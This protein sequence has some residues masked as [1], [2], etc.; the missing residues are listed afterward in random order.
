MPSS[1]RQM[2]GYVSC[3]CAGQGHRWGGRGGRVLLWS[4]FLTSA[5]V[6][7]ISLAFRW[8]REYGALDTNSPLLIWCEAEVTLAPW[9]GWKQQC[10]LPNS[11]WVVASGKRRREDSMW[12]RMRGSALPAS[13]L[14]ATPVSV[15]LGRKM[16]KIQYNVSSSQ[17][18]NSSVEF[19]GKAGLWSGIR[20]HQ[21]YKYTDNAS[22]PGPG[23]QSHS[24]GHASTRNQN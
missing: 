15:S 3:P 10:C 11:K 19:V 9:P 8:Y 2:H 17:R 16:P 12:E 1:H 21:S 22:T 18:P 14:Q 24:E 4:N 13:D 6:L 20:G 7:D 23:K 5:L